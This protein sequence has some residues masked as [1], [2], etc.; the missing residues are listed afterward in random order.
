MVVSPCSE[1][2]SRRVRSPKFSLNLT[3]PK[4]ILSIR[5]RS[6]SLMALRGYSTDRCVMSSSSNCKES[7]GGGIS[8][9]PSSLVPLSTSM[10]S[11]RRG[12][13]G[14]GSLSRTN[15]SSSTSDDES[16]GLGLGSS[17]G[18]DCMGLE[19][20]ANAVK[21]DNYEHEFN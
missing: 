15:V 12:R 20:G 17:C 13:S 1:K 9:L 16:S 7:R 14:K 18:D 21:N 3:S 11:D 8:G 10:G 6:F 19:M 2:A 4:L 5:C